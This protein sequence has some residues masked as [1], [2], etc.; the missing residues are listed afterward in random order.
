MKE[1]FTLMQA[2]FFAI[3]G[4]VTSGLA[5]LHYTGDEFVASLV[6]LAVFAT[7]GL[8]VV[9]AIYVV[10]AIEQSAKGEG[11]CPH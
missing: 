3:V 6:G 2:T 11:K 7:L 4:A 5:I 8:M 10:R 9:L 1:L